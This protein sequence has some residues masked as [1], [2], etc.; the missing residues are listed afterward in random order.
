MVAAAVAEAAAWRPHSLPVG[1]AA[2]FWRS[3]PVLVVAVVA[4][5]I[6]AALWRS[7]TSSVGCVKVVALLLSLAVC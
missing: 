6:Y 3:R 5:G 2:A 4:L 1:P 7:S